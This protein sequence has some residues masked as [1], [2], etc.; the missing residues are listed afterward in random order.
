M[1]ECAGLSS[2]A[3]GRRPWGNVRVGLQGLL[4]ERGRG[5]VSECGACPS[6]PTH[7]QFGNGGGLTHSSAGGWAR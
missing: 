2:F 4:Q 6:T 5:G 3:Y 1:M 7:S